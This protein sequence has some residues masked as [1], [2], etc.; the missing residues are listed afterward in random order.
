LSGGAQ[1]RA[2]QQHPQ[3]VSNSSDEL[4]LWAGLPPVLRLNRSLG[5]TLR[6]DGSELTPVSRTPWRTPYRNVFP[7]I[8]FAAILT[9]LFVLLW[10]GLRAQLCERLGSADSS[11]RS[12]LTL[13]RQKTASLPIRSATVQDRDRAVALLTMAHAQTPAWRNLYFFSAVALHSTY[14]SVLRSRLSSGRNGIQHRRHQQRASTATQLLSHSSRR[15][16][17]PELCLICVWAQETAGW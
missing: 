9:L 12:S 16:L 6:L 8:P 10:G 15:V 4:R 17:R 7:T 14:A 11:G 5:R 3:Y 2:V 13:L 1:R